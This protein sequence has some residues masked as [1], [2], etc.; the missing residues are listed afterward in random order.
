[1]QGGNGH[2]IAL[3]L[4]STRISVL[5]LPFRGEDKDCNHWGKHYCRPGLL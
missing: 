5:L 2:R 4:A 3:F 1:M